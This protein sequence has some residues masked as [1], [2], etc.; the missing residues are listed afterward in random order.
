MPRGPG[1]VWAWATN[2]RTTLSP[3][4]RYFEISFGGGRMLDVRRGP[5]RLIR[6]PTLLLAL[7]LVCGNNQQHVGVHAALLS[8]A[9]GRGHEEGPY[10][11]GGGGV[12]GAPATSATRERRKRWD[13]KAGKLRQEE[14]AR[15][16]CCSEHISSNGARLW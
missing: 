9:V 12:N 1:L 3:Q 5:P 11:G 7:A 8:T 13:W 10:G 15:D 16:L 6:A 2:E 4:A 14:E